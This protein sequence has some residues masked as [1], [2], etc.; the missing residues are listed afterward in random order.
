MHL[1]GSVIEDDNNTYHMFLS[2]FENHGG[3]SSWTSHSE[4]MHVVA[5]SPAGPF[6]PTAD[7][8]KHD[9]IVAGPEA[10]NPTVVRAND[11]TYLL[12]SIGK[13]K[14]AQR[15]NRRRKRARGH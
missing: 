13:V 3:L 12:F 15:S 7:G 10:H 2:V 8:P 1:A 6:E 11:G 5:T 9:G 4:I 14:N